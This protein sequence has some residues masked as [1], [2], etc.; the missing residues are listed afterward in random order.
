M[1]VGGFFFFGEMGTVGGFWP[2]AWKIADVEPEVKAGRPNRP[3]LS[4]G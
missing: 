2:E 1:E 3:W 4:R